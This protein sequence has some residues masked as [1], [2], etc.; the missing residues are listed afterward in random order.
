MSRKAKRNEFVSSLG[1]IFEIIK[2]ISDAIK[3][4]GG[5][6]EDFRRVLSE[7][8]LA[9]KIAEVIM[10]CTY[11][12]VVNYNKSLAEMIVSGK[13]GYVADEISEGKFPIQDAGSHEV[14]LVLVNLDKIASTTMVLEHLDKMGLKPAS[15]EHLLVFGATYPEIQEKFKIILLSSLFSSDHR[16]RAC[17]YLHHGGGKR[18]L[19]CDWREDNGLP[20]SVWGEWCRFLAVRK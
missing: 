1:I 12:V 20:N 10:A 19:G 14:N 3:A 16:L 9:E 13:Y 11:K 2:K 18:N 15:I 7:V 17:P 6:D 8:G 4:Q 5:N